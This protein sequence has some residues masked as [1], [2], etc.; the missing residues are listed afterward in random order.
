VKW[1]TG[2]ESNLPKGEYTVTVY[3]EEASG[4]GNEAGKST[5]DPS[6]I[7]TE[8]PKVSLVAPAKRLNGSPTFSGGGSE[9]GT[10]VV[11]RVMEGSKEVGKG[12]TTVGAGEK[13]STG[14]E[15]K[16]PEGEY[17]VTVYAEEISGLGNEAGKSTIDPSEIDTEAPKVSLVA[18]AKRLNG[19]PTFSGGGSEEGTEVVVRVMEGSKEVGK[20][21]TTV[22]AGEKWSTGLE[23]KLPE[24]EYAV[25]VYAEESSGL[26]NQAGK[27][28]IDPSEIDTKAPNIS[29][30]PLA[31][32]SN[33][34]T[35]TF[36]GKSNETTPVT[37]KIYKESAGTQTLEQTL[38]TQVSGGAYKVTASSALSNGEY[39]AV[40]SQPSGL[41]G[42]PSG[43]TPPAEFKI[44]TEAPQIEMDKPPAESNNQTPSFSGTVKA[45]KSEE[46]EVTVEVHEGASYLGPIVR[47][48][49]AK[50]SKE[51]WETGKVEALPPG[52][53]TYTAV[54][55]TESAL[56]NAEGKSAPATFVVNTEAPTVVLE[57]P[58]SPTNQRTPTFSGTANEE[59][60]VEVHV[61]EGTT[62]VVASGPTSHG[63]WSVMLP[64]P[65]PSGEHRFE[66]YA[67]ELS[68]LK[69]P[70]GRS[71]TWGFTLDTLPP[72]VVVTK[73]PP[74]ISSDRRP[75][76]TGTASDSTEV[77]VKIHQG[78]G[79]RP[80]AATL[81]A[82]VED[83]E[84]FV[85]V[86]EPLEFGQYTAIATQPSSLH[87][88]EPGNSSPFSFEVARISPVALTEAP[89]AVA[90]TH[91]AL[92][93]SVN[94]RGGPISSCAFEVGTT[95]AY[96]KK[97]ECGFVSGLSAFPSN[98]TGAVAVFVRVY[99]LRPNT[100]YHERLVAVGEGGTGAGTDQT[101]TTLPE[102]V[103]SGPAKQI[104]SSGTDT[105]K[106][107]GSSNVLG[108][109]AERLI[110]TGAEARI[111][112]LLRNDG[113][114]LR[115]S[116]PEAGTLK[117]TWFQPSQRVRGR[118]HSRTPE[119]IVA[120]GS[121]TVN[122]AGMA[123][124]KIKLT[125]A[126]RSLLKHTSRIKLST[127][128]VFT[129]A[130]GTPTKSS[131]SFTLLRR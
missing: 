35:P 91:V 44:N 74:A 121:I 126:G 75:L 45:P 28:S 27:S 6:E 96:G 37:V 40:A 65:L 3:A 128:T 18:P 61:L 113:Y 71:V 104:P 16:L 100:L 62:E 29:L 69:N 120:T 130:G 33:N 125:A 103:S 89:A 9:E 46:R 93:G 81:T 72:T 23:S 14:L 79:E 98:S 76:F 68:K 32:V 86:Q 60:E 118:A 95:T 107:T 51:H 52:R 88:N 31:L 1:S 70:P 110:P 58:A 101:F 119:V 39:E 90:E 2:L 38:V 115:F 122:A 11:V 49:K 66:V 7:D 94:P 57:Q 87:G 24:G 41:E 105:T 112:A 12:K 21:K 43:S 77:T 108:S 64:K 123:T 109:L 131:G 106:T 13:W 80:V 124:L 116:A 82:K 67:T 127:T 47:T 111:G 99:A 85:Q 34:T 17:A 8:A 129:P 25:T 22:G 4:L 78:S 114:R 36:S 48:L 73:G 10:G 92:Y 15:S 55:S 97:V 19:S 53:H 102:E 26:G 63:E 117:L 84:W 54:A 56:G 5:T 59:G 42:N 50:V 20:G 83:G 30:E